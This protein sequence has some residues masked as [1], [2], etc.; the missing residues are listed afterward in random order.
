M[1]VME[2]LLLVQ[3]GQL[4][5]G[6]GGR[7]TRNLKVKVDRF[8]VKVVYINKLTWKKKNCWLALPGCLPSNWPHSDECDHKT[9]PWKD[10]FHISCDRHIFKLDTK[11]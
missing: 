3:H 5:G 6:G 10:V 11:T 9:W 1:I 7:S 4:V 2:H 8:N